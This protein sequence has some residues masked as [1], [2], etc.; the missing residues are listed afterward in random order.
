MALE[1]LNPPFL[2]YAGKLGRRIDVDLLIQLADAMPRGT[3]V[4]AGQIL[5]RRLIRPVLKHARIRYVGDL[6]YSQLPGFIAAC[7]VC[8]VPHRLGVGE[9]QGDPTKIYEYL[10]ARKPVITTAIGGVERFQGRVVIANAKTSF[11]EAALAAARGD[12]VVRGEVLPSETWEARTA[13]IC[14]YF[15]LS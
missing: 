1:G 14:S 13:A 9:N 15:G 11:V 7:H 8:I 12:Q 3:I 10:A 2:G 5:N 4:I 6:H